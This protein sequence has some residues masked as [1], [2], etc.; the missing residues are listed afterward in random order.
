MPAKQNRGDIM[1][2]NPS[3]AVLAREAEY[4]EKIRKATKK[5]AG[6]ICHK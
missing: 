4:W 1:K 6:R 3:K 5:G 2:K